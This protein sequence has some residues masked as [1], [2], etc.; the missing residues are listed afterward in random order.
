MNIDKMIK[1]KM[2]ELSKK[3]DISMIEI[4][5]VKDNRISRTIT[6]NYCLL[7]DTEAEKYTKKFYSKRDLVSWLV[8]LT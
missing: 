8:C 5:K 7:N 4:S 1:I 6:I 2:I 3:Y